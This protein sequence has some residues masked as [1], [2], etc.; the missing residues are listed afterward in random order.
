MAWSSLWLT[1]LK[2]EPELEYGELQSK[3]ILVIS[4]E[5]IIGKKF[6]SIELSKN[7]VDF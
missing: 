6:L 2:T 1:A 3:H 4:F 5:E 7:R